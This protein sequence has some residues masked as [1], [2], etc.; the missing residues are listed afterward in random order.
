[1]ALIC[2]GLSLRRLP[3][4]TSHR[5]A[6]QAAANS[7]APRVSVAEAAHDASSPAPCASDASAAAWLLA[8]A[9]SRRPLGRR[10][11]GGPAYEWLQKEVRWLAQEYTLFLEDATCGWLPAGSE[12]ESL[13]HAAARARFGPPAL[14]RHLARRLSELELHGHASPRAV[15]NASV[16]VWHANA[17][18]GVWHEP[19]VWSAFSLALQVRL[20]PVYE[21]GWRDSVEWSVY[22]ELRPKAA[23][24]GWELRVSQPAR[25]RAPRA[26]AAARR[27]ETHGGGG[28]GSGGSGDGGRREPNPK[29]PLGKRQVGAATLAWLHTAA[30]G[31]AGEYLS[32]VERLRAEGGSL[33][34]EALHAAAAPTFA[35]R[36]VVLR[37]DEILAALGRP[38]EVPEGRAAEVRTHVPTVWSAFACAVRARLLERG[39][40]HAAGGERGGG[41]S[42]RG[43]DRWSESVEWRLLRRLYEAGRSSEGF[44]WRIAAA[45]DAAGGE[46][47]AAGVGTAAGV[48]A[49]PRV[50][51]GRN[52]YQ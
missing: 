5:S 32:L 43:D 40:G 52:E 7:P 50:G 14:Q 16:G 44:A 33:T 6:P 24:E 11:L 9:R 25:R 4:R 8:A 41:E 36:A 2:L 38:P 18:V 35:P 31:L 15:A 28:G 12:E 21:G 3:T 1:M 30:G 48:G 10:A 37:C 20:E 47:E 13:V 17:S 34:V 39:G 26:R 42:E 27:E 49:K 51:R 23:A 46:R 29:Q 22:A 45:S 19:T